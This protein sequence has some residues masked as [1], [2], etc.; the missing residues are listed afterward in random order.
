[1]AGAKH[2][3]RSIAQAVAEAALEASAKVG[4]KAVKRALESVVEDAD[5]AAQEIARRTGVT[6]DRFRTDRVPFEVRQVPEE[7]PMGR[8]ARDEEEEER[9]DSE[10]DENPEEEE[11]RK[12]VGPDLIDMQDAEVLLRQAW[13]LLADLAERGKYSQKK[14][15]Q[16]EEMVG[17]LGDRLEELA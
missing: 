11:E 5:K 2:G 8:R 9:D 17:D 1:M 15:R 10:E 12:A 4:E 16:I 6:R 3:P 13:M 14:A 7:D